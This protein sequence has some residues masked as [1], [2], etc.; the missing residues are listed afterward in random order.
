MANAVLLAATYRYLPETVVTHWGITGQPDGFSKKFWGVI[1]FPIMNLVMWIMYRV[2]PLVEPKNKSGKVFE[3]GY[4]EVMLWIFGFLN[5]V[6]LLFV[7][8]N[9][10]L[11]FSVAKMILPGLGLMFAGIGKEMARLE[12]NYFVGIKTPWTLASEKVWTKTHLLGG[13]L[14]ISAGILMLLGIFLPE[15]WSFWLL[16]VLVAG[17]V[18]GTMFYSYFVYRAELGK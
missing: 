3:K 10:G 16:M 13:K 4:E 7:L 14:F 17:M 15:V 6:S 5:Y 1:L 2:V 12:P 18:L 11:R 8:S 9:L